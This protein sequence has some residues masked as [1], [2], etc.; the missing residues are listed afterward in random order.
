MNGMA[1]L[2]NSRVTM[3]LMPTRFS[4]RWTYRIFSRETFSRGTNTAEPLAGQSEKIKSFSSWAIKD[5]GLRRNKHRLIHRFSHPP[6]FKAI[7][8]RRSLIAHYPAAR[9]KWSGDAQIPV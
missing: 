6:N 9:V 2:L 4:T 7:F 8:R 1:A 5:N 3:R